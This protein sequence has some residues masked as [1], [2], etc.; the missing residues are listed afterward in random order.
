MCGKDSV[1]LRHMRDAARTGMRLA[2]GRV[3]RCGS[4]RFP[5]YARGRFGAGSLGAPASRRPMRE[6]HSEEDAGE[7][8]AHSGDREKCGRKWSPSMRDGRSRLLDMLAFT[9]PPAFAEREFS[10]SRPKGRD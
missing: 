4:P 10:R 7:T 6:A 1:R 2:D 9:E 5:D 8:P 3:R